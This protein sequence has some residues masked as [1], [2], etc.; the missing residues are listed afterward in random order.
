[1]LEELKDG[2]VELG[3]EGGRGA[4]NAG[5]AGQGVGSRRSE[6][7]RSC[8][9][10]Q[11]LGEELRWFHVESVVDAVEG[12]S[13]GQ[14]EPGSM[15]DADKTL[16]PFPNLVNSE[17][18]TDW[19]K[20]LLWMEDDM[21]LEERTNNNMFLTGNS[22]RDVSS[23]E[24][25]QHLSSD[26]RP[27]NQRSILLF[28][29]LPAVHQGQ[30][31]GL[32]MYILGY[33]AADG[34]FFVRRFERLSSKIEL[35]PRYWDCGKEKACLSI[36]GVL[37]IIRDVNLSAAS[38]SHASVFP[39][40]DEEFGF[41]VVVLAMFAQWVLDFSS[42]F[43]MTEEVEEMAA[44]LLW[45]WRYSLLTRSAGAR[46]CM[47]KF[48]DEKANQR[49]SGGCERGETQAV[50]EWSTRP[51]S[52]LSGSSGSSQDSAVDDNEKTDQVSSP[53]ATTP[54]DRRATTYD[55]D[56]EEEWAA[57]QE[58]AARSK[59]RNATQNVSAEPA[60][61]SVATRPENSP[62]SP[63]SLT[64]ALMTPERE[65]SP[66]DMSD[67]A[68]PVNA[69]RFSDTS[70]LCDE[71][72]ENKETFAFANA[73]RHAMLKEGSIEAMLKIYL[74]FVKEHPE[75]DSRKKRADLFDFL[76]A[77]VG[78]KYGGSLSVIE[79]LAVLEKMGLAEEKAAE[80]NLEIVGRGSKSG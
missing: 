71:G 9:W 55:S 72:E 30:H 17:G 62:D 44:M 26:A 14:E 3:D 10:Q 67:P 19:A 52:P 80:A 13:N 25:L 31:D 1:M 39:E 37:Q 73:I 38:T 69:K 61:G 36:G 16:P 68:K 6:G 64:S 5:G 53:I 75:H 70:T 65:D 78:S 29:D 32:A 50:G 48:D 79:T 11:V 43:R 46:A 4:T 33:D 47:H 40:W 59:L 63:L 21:S 35:L 24:V 76:V 58:W 74:E 18:E 12:A 45:N 7:K 15:E 77:H 54:N 60:A 57:L 51:K 2:C 41:K 8:A 28:K 56:E 23:D 22:I 27:T 66:F 34:L 49:P 42:G 20:Y